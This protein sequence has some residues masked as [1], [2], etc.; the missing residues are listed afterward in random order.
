[1]VFDSGRFLYRY[2]KR[3]LVVSLPYYV[4]GCKLIIVLLKLEVSCPWL[5]VVRGESTSLFGSSLEM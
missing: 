1:M 5:L 4:N 3:M 2:R